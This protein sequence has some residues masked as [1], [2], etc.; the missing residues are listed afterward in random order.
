MNH[1]I[2]VYFQIENNCGG[3]YSEEDEIGVYTVI[4]ATSVDLEL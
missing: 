1:S 2:K 4:N 3:F